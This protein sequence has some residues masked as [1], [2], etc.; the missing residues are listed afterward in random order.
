[1]SAKIKDVLWPAPPHTLAKISILQ[2]YLTRWFEILGRS[3]FRQNLWYIDGF[4]GPGEYTNSATGSPVAAIASA[5]DALQSV[6][7]QWKAGGVHCVFIEENPDRFAHLK[8]KLGATANHQ[9]IHTYFSNSTFVDGLTA[10]RKQAHNPFS[11]PSPLFAFVDPFG[12]KGVPFSDIKD[13][14]SR[15]S[16]E[17]LINFDSD[18]IGRIF[19]A[20]EAANHEEILNEIFGDDSWRTELAIHRKSHELYRGVLALYKQKLLALPKVR[21]VFAFEMRSAK[22]TLDYHLVFA[23]QHPLGLEK[24]KEAM[25]TIAKNGDYCFS[26]AHLHQSSMFRFDE[27]PAY[28]PQLFEHFCGRTASYSELND[29]ALNE[30]PFM[31]PKSMLK[32]LEV[33]GMIQVSSRD[34]KRRKG[35]FNEE[36]LISIMF[37]QGN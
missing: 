35:T 7:A 19:R 24:M 2:A 9:K 37:Q 6:S 11:P 18:G 3:K 15:E 17:I 8:N 31:N 32:D 26:D 36:H 33:K 34:T 5:S 29:Y 10:L 28:S 4:A 16:S 1:M 30:T 12:A 20:E 14:L 21:Y 23:S 22:N 13:L 27:P 25:K